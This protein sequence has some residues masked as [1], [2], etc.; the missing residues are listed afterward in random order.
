MVEP[1]FVEAIHLTETFK[2]AGK[3]KSFFVTV[4]DVAPS[5][6][7]PRVKFSVFPLNVY[8]AVHVNFLLEYPCPQL[9]PEHDV[10]IVEYLV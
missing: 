1:T 10:V 2:S 3:L 8:E 7:V 4:L 6:Q 5:V 9:I